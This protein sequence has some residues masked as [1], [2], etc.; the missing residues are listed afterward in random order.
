MN[1]FEENKK[2]MEIIDKATFHIDKKI[3][4]ESGKEFNK[5]VQKLIKSY[6]NKNL[7]P[8]LKK[9]EEGKLSNIIEAAQILREN[10]SKEKIIK[11][12]QSKMYN[13]IYKTMREY[14]QKN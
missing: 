10:N 2:R 7:D 5:L 6:N 1:R 14:M 9:V 12:Y 3:I 8:E 4:D 11:E 13:H